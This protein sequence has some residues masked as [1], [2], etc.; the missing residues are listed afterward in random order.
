MKKILTF[1]GTV[2]AV[3][4]INS[5]VM[6]EDIT[7]FYTNDIHTYIAND[8]GEGN[9][10][11]FTYSKVAALKEN[12]KN[13]V[14]VD[15]G[16]H[17]QGTAYGGMD[18]GAKIIELMNA[19]GYDV[20]TAGNHEF[21]YGM[22]TFLKNVDSS[23]F[24][25]TSANFYHE[26]DGKKV[27]LVLDGYVMTEVDGKK[28]AFVGITTPESI[29]SSTPAYFQN[30]NGEYIYGISGGEDG[31]ELYSD[32]QT[33]IN[34]AENAGA[35]YI[36]A[37]GHLGIDPSSGAWTSENLIKNTEGF[38]AFIDGHSHSVIDKKIVLDKKG[39]E[40]VLT[41][42]GSYF[43][44]I[45]KMIISDDGTIT[46]ELLNTDSLIVPSDD[47][48]KIEQAWIEEIDGVLNEVIGYSDVVLDNYDENGN[49]LVRKQSTNTGDFAA[50]ALYYLFDEM[51]IDVDVAI[52]NGGGI[53]N[54]AVTGEISYNTCKQI[55]TFGN[56]A[57]LQTVTGQQLL[58]ALEWGVSEATADGT[59]EN[60]GFL[61]VSRLK[62]TVDLTVPSTVLVDD[63]G[64]WAGPPTGEYRVKDVQVLNNQTGEYEPLVLDE[65]YNLAG[66]NY[67]LRNLGD[68]FN[69]FGDA[70]NVLDYVAEDYMVLANYVQSFPENENTGLPTITEKDGYSDV[71]G[72][73]RITIITTKEDT[74]AD[75]VSELVNNEGF[76]T[77][78]MIVT[79]LYRA[80]GAPEVLNEASFDDVLP[81]S[82]YTKAIA[83]AKESGIV[84]G[85]SEKTFAPMDGV[86]REQ[87]AAI[88][89]RYAKYKGV[90]VSVG[91][92]V[93]S[94]DDADMIS[95]YA[96]QAV[97]YAVESGLMN[98]KTAT[99]IN[100]KDNITNV[101]SALVLGRFFGV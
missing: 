13:S 8:L 76:L 79:A 16:D 35:D 99:T 37:L 15:A 56:V 18:Y 90:D 68:G 9:E 58:D 65:K 85:Y 34:L 27:D 44:H 59:T 91:E 66:Y 39:N 83:W 14:L 52:M 10:N 41:Q 28:I 97:C 49:R 22:E 3:S 19:A 94:F 2:F 45:G 29:A 6:A 101:E 5:A 95:E 86:L 46:T 100:P 42:T 43:D 38:D 32:V 72:S 87:M 88:M 77:R 67:T 81:G 73:G 82:D 50:D 21:D 70:V 57:C 30:D 33:A 4:V 69:M 24:V 89:Y 26:S 17:V 64:I 12:T 1:L 31:T 51:D 53:R 25:Y 98:G 80:E 75:I 23:E 78:A 84:N 48:K 47:V 7:I 71:K 61:H 74:K 55:H 20:A 40:V 62:Y 60:G 54:K 92:N 11:K 63:K 36:I 93:L 96:V